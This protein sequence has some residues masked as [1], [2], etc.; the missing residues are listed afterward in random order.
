MYAYDSDVN[1]ILIIP[2]QVW[3]IGMHENK[4]VVHT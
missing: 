3:R 1:V 4:I 2:V